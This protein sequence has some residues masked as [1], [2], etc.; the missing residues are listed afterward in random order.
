[1]TSTSST[2]SDS[3]AQ[4]ISFLKKNGSKISLHFDENGKPQSLV[5]NPWFNNKTNYNIGELP[6]S[7]EQSA[8]ISSFCT[9]HNI[10]QELKYVYELVAHTGGEFSIGIWQFLS[11]QKSD[12][13][14]N[15]K[16]HML[17]IAIQYAG[18]GHIE[19]LTMDKDTKEFFV[20][21]DGGSNDFEREDYFEKYKTMKPT[22]SGDYEMMTFTQAL[23]M[24][25]EL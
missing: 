20:R 11:I 17:D 5:D 6:T 8:L 10:P 4:M 7:A 15:G 14:S 9:K 12:E 19:V 13:M 2:M 1:M 23:H 18:M 21:S 22:E 16:L 25:I 3:K 24:M